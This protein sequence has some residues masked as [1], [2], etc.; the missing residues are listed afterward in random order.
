MPEQDRYQHLEAGDGDRLVAT[1]EVTTSAGS[2][3]TARV[4]LHAEPG[5]IGPGRRAWLVDAVLDLP[6]VR[7]SAR[8]VAAFWR[9][10]SESLR[11]LQERCESVTTHPAGWSVLFTGNLPSGGAGRAPRDPAAGD[12]A[13][14]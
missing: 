1:A 6:E 10:D 9:G 3:G 11:R 13:Q 8:L 7:D 14:R 12:P 2:G 5:H 4:S